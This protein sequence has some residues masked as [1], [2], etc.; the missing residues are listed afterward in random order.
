MIKENIST[1]QGTLLEI[2]ANLGY[3]CHKFEDE[4]FERYASEENRVSL[5]FLKKLKKAKIKSSK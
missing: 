3:S 1:S 2:G 5:Y 4:G